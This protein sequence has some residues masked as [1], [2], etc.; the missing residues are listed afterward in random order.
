MFNLLLPIILATSLSVRSPNI[1][2]NPFDYQIQFSIQKSDYFYVS[3]C[4]EREL[5]IEYIDEEYWTQKRLGNFS[6]K[7]RYLNKTSKDLK[8]NQLD[9]RYNHKGF[10]GGYALK[11]IESELKPTHNLIFGYKIKD[12]NLDIFILKF[13]LNSNL[14]FT[15]NFNRL[16]ISTNTNLKFSLLQ[17]L[18]LVASYKYESIGSNEFYQLKLGLSFEISGKRK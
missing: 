2:P 18:D 10:N 17:N 8:Y 5:G 1:S 14:D 4:W 7:E 9:V 12:K 11:H 6:V 13:R 3:R 16:D 15:T